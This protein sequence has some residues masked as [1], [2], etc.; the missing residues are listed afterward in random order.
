MK[1]LNELINEK[2]KI[3]KQKSAKKIKVKDRHELIQIVKERY[4]ENK[5]HIDLTDIDASALKSLDMVFYEMKELESVDLSGWDVSNVVTATSMFHG[6][7]HLKNIDLSDWKMHEL[8]EADA[9]F[10]KCL[11]LL[12]IDCD[13]LTYTDKLNDVSHMFSWC[14]ALSK[15]PNIENVNVA[16]IKDFGYMFNKCYSLKELDL[17][18]WKIQNTS[19]FRNMFEECMNL[20][21][22]KG[23]DKW[24]LNGREANIN[25]MFDGCT[26]LDID[27][28]NWKNL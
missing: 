26:K 20:K 4:A 3:G 22:L 21:E 8:M 17:S 18:K 23:V 2:L 1:H 7:V 11:L 24:N 16:S 12:E 28:S 19:C 10:Y 5:K 14:A 13:F 27:L 6:C 25:D 15:L 9:M